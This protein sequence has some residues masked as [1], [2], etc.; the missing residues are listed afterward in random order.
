[1]EGINQ[2]EVMPKSDHADGQVKKCCLLFRPFLT[3][4]EEEQGCNG[5][6]EGHGY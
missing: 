6:Q 2:T 3:R 5:Q 4:P 1:M